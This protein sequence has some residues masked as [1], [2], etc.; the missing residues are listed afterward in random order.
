M[1]SLIHILCWFGYLIEGFEIYPN[2]NMKL[3]LKHL[4]PDDKFRAKDILDMDNITC[5]GWKEPE[6]YR[7][8]NP[9]IP[10]VQEVPYY[11]VFLQESDKSINIELIVKTVTPR[12]VRK[13]VPNYAEDVVNE[14]KQ[15][16]ALQG[17]NMTFLKLRD[18]GLDN[19]YL[20]FMW[21]IPFFGGG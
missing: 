1:K 15:Y 20:E 18:N 19:W 16:T 10:W 6:S 7:N 14:M 13:S 21:G 5:L 8:M 3:R 17:G 11:Y 4:E 9:H 2:Q 12:R